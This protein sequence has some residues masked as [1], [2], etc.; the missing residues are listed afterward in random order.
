MNAQHPPI[1]EV[2]V[3]AYNSESEL[4]RLLRSVDR[5]FRPGTR[6]SIWS[7]SDVERLKT[8]L[9]DVLSTTSILI[10][11]RGDGSNLGFAEACNRL[12]AASTRSVGCWA[13]P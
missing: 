3:V 10:N 8:A 1:W 7:N 2:L 5:Q 11:V 12:A 4:P 13:A 9:A 6:V